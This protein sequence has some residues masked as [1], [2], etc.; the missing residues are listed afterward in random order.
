M[1]PHR[2]PTRRSRISRQ[3]IRWAMVPAAALALLA[4]APAARAAS[5]AYRLG[6]QDKI[7][8]QVYEWRA[9]KGDVFEWKALN[10]EFT[11]GAGGNLSLPLIG[12]VHAAGLYPAEV[13]AAVSKRLKERVGLLQPPDAAVEVV[14]YRP[15]YIVGAVEHPGAF[16]YQPGLSVLQAVGVAG[17]LRRP[18]EGG[19]RQ[20]E[21]E[22]I[23]GQGDLTVYALDTRNLLA[24][25]ARL[26][27]ELNGRDKIDW[28]AELNGK[29]DPSVAQLKSQEN[30]I[31]QT[32]RDA[33]QTQLQS[34]SQLRSFLDSEVKSISDQ[35]AI[36]DRQLGLIRK[37]LK[38]VS[39]LREK[40]LVVAP[41]VLSLERTEA[42]AEADRL[43]MNTALLQAKQEGGKTELAMIELKNNR[44]N[45]IV[46]T[47]RETQ[48]KLDE[49][50]KRA[51]TTAALVQDS[52][53]AVPRLLSQQQNAQANGPTYVIVRQEG[54]HAVEHKATETSAVQPGDIVKVEMP[55]IVDFDAG[56]LVG[57][58]APTPGDQ[59][60]PHLAAAPASTPTPFGVLVRAPAAGASTPQD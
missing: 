59:A 55:R 40:G 56:R 38:S 53:D 37:E 2:A 45:E 4:A 26:T 1:T 58:L 41:R 51:G 30:L 39:S 22:I 54:G 25:R 57:L 6:A 10:G 31:F 43:R 47:L 3:A 27:A 8:L 13:A 46:T 49:I 35:L 19:V 11:V 18:I 9:A 16:P 15:F 28:P 29:N 44:H 24:R 7:R 42:E 21:R 20:V 60:S 34:L 48:A 52:T 32:R 5:D 23:S 33:L 12:E 17:G 36:Q 50:A 14:Q